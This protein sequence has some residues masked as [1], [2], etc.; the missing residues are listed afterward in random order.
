[1]A[2]VETGT[3]NYFI[4]VGSSSDD[5]TFYYDKYTKV[6]YVKDNYGFDGY[7]GG[8]TVLYNADGTVMTYDDWN[9]LEPDTYVEANNEKGR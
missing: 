5:Y 7:G 8:I 6:M 2:I 4:R 3:S 9:K 1:M